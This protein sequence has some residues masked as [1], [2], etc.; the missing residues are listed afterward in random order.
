VDPARRRGGLLILGTAGT[1]ILVDRFSKIWAERSFAAHPRDVIEGVLTLRFTTNS[2]G[3]FSFGDRTP[4]LFAAAAIVVCLAILA[5]AFRARPTLHAVAL[6]L[7]LGGAFGNLLDRIL[8]GPGLSGRVV[9]FIDPHV[10]PVFNLADAAVVS[11][12]VLLAVQSFREGRTAR[13][14]VTIDA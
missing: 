11:G 10:W 12:A 8:R 6:G 2:G 14:D 4:L 13:A 3:A 5:T 7:I 9:D 1:V